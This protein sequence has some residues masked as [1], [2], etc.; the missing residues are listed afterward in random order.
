V[1]CLPLGCCFSDLSLNNPTHRVNI[2]IKSSKC[3]LY[4]PW[5]SWKIVHMSLINMHS[6]SCWTCYNGET[7]TSN[8]IH[9]DV[10]LV[11]M[12]KL[13]PPTVYIKMWYCYMSFTPVNLSCFRTKH[14]I[15]TTAT[16]V[17]YKLFLVRSW[18]HDWSRGDN[19]CFNIILYL[20]GQY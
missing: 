20:T 1:T 4:S 6:Y 16:N 9:K 19:S 8:S 14:I 3:N 7:S 17:N 15:L 2:I 18:L 12:G 13:Q 11:T 5:L 10:E